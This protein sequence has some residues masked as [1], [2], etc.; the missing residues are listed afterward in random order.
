MTSVIVQ[1]PLNGDKSIVE[2]T[3]G[4]GNGNP[5]KFFNK[6]AAIIY[7]IENHYRNLTVQEI[8]D[9]FIF[10]KVTDGENNN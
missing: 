5:K 7:L 3:M 8:K 1:K 6:E 10:K 9:N 2:A 4:D